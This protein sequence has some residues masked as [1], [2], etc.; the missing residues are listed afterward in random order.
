MKKLL[1][2]MLFSVMLTGC[3]AGLGPFTVE[4][5]LQ[6]CVVVKLDEGSAT[7]GPMMFSGKGVVYHS[8]KDEWCAKALKHKGGHALSE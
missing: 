7:I 3:A 8:I 1:V 5:G 6:K 4:P 2:I